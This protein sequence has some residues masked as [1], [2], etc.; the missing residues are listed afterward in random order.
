MIIDHLLDAHALVHADRLG[1]FAK[2]ARQLNIPVA[3]FS[4][5]IAK[6]EAELGVRIFNRTTRSLRTTEMGELIVAHAQ[7][8]L[9][10]AEHATTLV[11][12]VRG[13]PTGRIRIAS[14]SIFGQAFLQTALSSFL[15]QNP[16]C[17]VFVELT[18][19]QVDLVYDNYDLAI[20]LGNP[21]DLDSI[22]RPLGTLTASLYRKASNE[23]S[24]ISDPHDLQNQKLALLRPRHYPW[25]ELTLTHDSG[26][27]ISLPVEPRFVSTNPN[28]LREISIERGFIFVLPDF[29][30]DSTTTP[31][32]PVLPEYTVT[33]LDVYVVYTTRTHMRPA[34]RA[35]LDCLFEHVA[36]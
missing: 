5:R 19:R 10:E 22:A 31:I 2:A 36:L 3:T 24:A 16:K 9:D 32:E 6:L 21:G 1:S 27:Q 26:Q 20:R 7:R 30:V 29:M 17:D 28:L 23:I 12:S 8:L 25:S 35:F 18:N 4:R 11:E 13:E 34:V 33:L 15:D 14:P